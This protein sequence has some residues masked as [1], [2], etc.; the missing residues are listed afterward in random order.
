MP[1]QG[2]FFQNPGGA[3]GF[4]DYQIQQS[5]R[6]DRASDSRL[7]RTFGTASSLKKLGVNFIY[8]N[9]S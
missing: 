4:Y 8:L 7:T 1:V 9:I 6:F 3:G 2:E 5:A